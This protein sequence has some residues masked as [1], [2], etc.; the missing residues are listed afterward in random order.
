M[1]DTKG[2][3]RDAALWTLRQWREGGRPE[4][5]IKESFSRFSLERR[6]RALAMELSYG[7]VRNLIFLDYILSKFISETKKGVPDNMRDILRLAAYQILF[8]TKVPP[9][10]AVN[11]AV[12]EAKRIKGQS[13]GGFVNAVLR[14]L[15]RGREAAGLDELSGDPLRQAA[16]RY[17]YPDWL[18][19]RWAD[20]LG[21][22]G[23]V[24]LMKAGDAVPPVTLCVNTLKT[25]REE[26]KALLISKGIRCAE[27]GISP[28]GLSVSG[29]PSVA[30]LP[31][32]SE[33]L[34]W[35][36]DEAA[37]F[38]SMLLAPPPLTKGGRGDFTVLDACAAPGGKSAHLYVLSGGRARII[39]MDIGLDKLRLLEEN[40]GRLG[41]T[42]VKA[43]LAD[44]AGPLPFREQF[45]AVL[46][47]APCS[48]LGVIRRRPEIKYARRPED[49][50]RLAELQVRMLGNVAKYLKPGGILVYSVCS[51]EPEEGERVIEGFLSG[52][53]DL[54]LDDPR[55]FLPE[56]ARGLADEKGYVRTWPHLHGTD[57]FFMAR[58]IKVHPPLKK[59]D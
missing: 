53:G 23:A 26:L 34:F 13:A 42:G 51:T 52:N 44:L 5:L 2:S 38:V 3:A 48:A 58:L 15:L 39:S 30:E 46:L 40:T 21:L 11:E 36:Q 10:A 55:P 18:A 16:I 33:G 32:Y 57:G 50:L 45:D 8:L 4:L 29:A 54:R 7:V 49:I 56:A 20:R 28:Y 59:G 37:Q 12:T 24:S 31:G 25:T 27:T 17:S 43:V 22:E 41:F 14:S 1:P 9:H 47:D 6:D 35:V 19:M